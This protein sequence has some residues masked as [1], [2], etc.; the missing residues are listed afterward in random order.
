MQ[1]RNEVRDGRKRRASPADL[2]EQGRLGEGGTPQASNGLSERA[3]G[4]G[5]RSL[6][7]VELLLSEEIALKLG[8][9]EVG[10]DLRVCCGV[11]FLRGCQL[12]EGRG[13]AFR[14]L[15]EVARND[16]QHLAKRRRGAIHRLA[17]RGTGRDSPEQQV[18]RCGRGDAHDEHLEDLHNLVV[19]EDIVDD[20]VFLGDDA[21]DGE[22][23]QRAADV[24]ERVGHL[25]L[26]PAHEAE[27]AADEDDDD[28][29]VRQRDEAENGADEHRGGHGEYG[30]NLG[31]GDGDAGDKNGLDHGAGG[32]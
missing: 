5:G 26:D 31:V 4:S 3:N 11:C 1:R 15:E 19:G 29:D 27:A 24:D 7:G 9:A 16:G 18:D 20:G 32:A 2:L 14:T 17:K 25:L 6:E 8:L 10:H 30:Y 12:G 22:R 13:V 28:K 23:G 21:D